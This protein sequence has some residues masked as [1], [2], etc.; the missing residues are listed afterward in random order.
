LQHWTLTSSS[1]AEED[2]QVLPLPV[3]D[4]WLGEL[5]KNPTYRNCTL[6]GSLVPVNSSSSNEGGGGGGRQRQP[7]IR[8]ELTDCRSVAVEYAP[9]LRGYWVQT[10]SSAWYWLRQPSA[11]QRGLEWNTSLPALAVLCNLV[12]CVFTGERAKKEKYT[13]KNIQDVH[14]EVRAR[15]E[16]ERLR[17]GHRADGDGS[18]DEPFDMELAAAFKNVLLLHMKVQA[19]PGLTPRSGFMASLRALPSVHLTDERLQRAV[20]AS[21]VRSRRYAWGQP[22]P[23]GVDEPPPLAV[24]NEPVAPAAAAVGER[25]NKQQQRQEKHKEEKSKRQVQTKKKKKK[26]KRVLEDIDDDDDDDEGGGAVRVVKPRMEERHSKGGVE[27]PGTSSK[28]SEGKVGQE[29]EEPIAASKKRK[30]AS[31]GSKDRRP[32]SE[33]PEV[34]QGGQPSKK[35]I[36]KADDGLFSPDRMRGA[37]VCTSSFY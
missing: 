25:P 18:L 22:L 30:S 17:A 21:L 7:T 35:K 15:R 19:F 5:A 20:T 14:S 1:S 29:E 13:E 16:R 12:D 37:L 27:S 10:S 8:V 23:S 32:G 24:P 2:G 28:Q 4:P 36:N 31:S 6:T 3:E 26:K 11:E 9:H 34:E 33:I